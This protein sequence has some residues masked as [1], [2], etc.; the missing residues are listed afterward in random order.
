[1]EGSFLNN[2]NLGWLGCVWALSIVLGM[3]AFLIWLVCPTVWNADLRR[4]VQKTSQ[5]REAFLAELPTLKLVNLTLQPATLR[6]TNEIISQTSPD[7]CAALPI[8]DT[9]RSFLSHWWIGLRSPTE[10]ADSTSYRSVT[11]FPDLASPRAWLLLPPL[12]DKGVIVLDVSAKDYG[13]H[14]TDRF[15]SRTYHFQIHQVPKSRPTAYKLVFEKE[16][17]VSWPYVGI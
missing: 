12:K 5:T 14:S 4:M 9:V 13:D 10:L 2:Q 15:L 8:T 16:T 17:E 3:V 7:V 1:M 6:A 11:P